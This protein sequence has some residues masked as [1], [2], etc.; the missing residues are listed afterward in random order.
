MSQTDILGF[1]PVS[2]CEIWH[3]AELQTPTKDLQKEQTYKALLIVDG[4]GRSLL[5]PLRAQEQQCQTPLL[6]G[7]LRTLLIGQDCLCRQAGSSPWPG[8]GI[9]AAPQG[10]LQCGFWPV[11]ILLFILN[12]LHWHLL[13]VLPLRPTASTHRRANGPIHD[14]I[15]IPFNAKQ[16]SKTPLIQ[17][18]R[19]E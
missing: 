14:P 8:R 17:A 15:P 11:S 10:P 16:S 5:S 6:L 13:S 18:T 9:I 12:N 7:C 1:S 4:T 2:H 3:R 19:S